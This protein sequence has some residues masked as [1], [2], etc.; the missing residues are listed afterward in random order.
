MAGIPSFLWRRLSWICPVLFNS[1]SLLPF[2]PLGIP[3]C[4]A[5]PKSMIIPWLLAPV[6]MKRRFILISQWSLEAASSLI[7]W[8]SFSNPIKPL[9][10]VVNS[11]KMNTL[12]APGGS[13]DFN[14]TAFPPW[15]HI[16]IIALDLPTIG[17]REREYMI[18]LKR[19]KPWAAFSLCSIPW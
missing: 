9:S 18:F 12:S 16:Y 11:R 17:S 15:K 8:L 5:A 2:T 14:N 3:A 19:G 7:L 1:L 10:Q 13:L 4:E 6:L